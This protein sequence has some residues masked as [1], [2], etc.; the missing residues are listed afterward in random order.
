VRY[1]LTINGER[2]DV[3]V[4]P[5]TTL[6]SVLRDDLELTGTRYGCGRG[7]CGACYVIADGRAVAACLMTVE[8]A[9]AQALTTV[10]GLADGETLHPIQA[11]FVAEDAMQCGYCTTGM[12]ISAAALLANDPD[13]D[14]GT[15]RETLAKHLCRCGVYGRAIRA[16]Q[17]AAVN[18]RDTGAAR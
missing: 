5:Q 16:V 2:R 17:R 12:L 11:A 6:L 3:D 14:E 15:I 10:E 7:Q 8:Q 1:T 9:A 13:P 18:G 4:A